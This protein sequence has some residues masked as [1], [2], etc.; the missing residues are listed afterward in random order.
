MAEARALSGKS[1]W[2]VTTGEPLPVDGAGVRLLRHGLLARMLAERGWNV[3]WWTSAF[4]HTSKRHRTDGVNGICEMAPNF[5]LVLLPSCGYRR[6]ISLARFR[7]HAQIARAFGDRAAR[8]PAPDVV[9]CSYPTLE[10]S[11]AATRYGAAHGVPVVLDVRDL[12]PEIFLELVPRWARPLA[13]LA[14]YRSFR[15]SSRCLQGASAI[16]GITQPIRDWALRRAGRPAGPQ[17]R[18]FHLAYAEPVLSDQVRMEAEARWDRLGVMADKFLVCFF[19]ALGHQFDFDTVLQAAESLQSRHPEVRFVLCGSGHRL[20]PLQAAARRSSNL[21]VPGW[22]GQADI[23]VLMR[24]A[25]CGLAPYINE[26]SFTLSVPNK[27]IEYCAGALPVVSCLQGETA[28]LLS[29]HAIGIHYVEYDSASLAKAVG[30]LVVND[31]RRQAMARRARKL[32][33]SDVSAAHVYGLMIDQLNRIAL[34]PLLN[35]PALCVPT[36]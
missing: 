31:G 2:L 19:G 4:D 23:W 27:I 13:R 20:E 15:M 34:R 26:Y 9:L 14:L 12:W 10:L 16:F 30:D 3:T 1:I 7:D 29:T 24:R 21:V 36:A 17:D 28:I 18:V 5:R 25:A 11:D 6:N 33:E 35:Q 22:V 8:Q 32:F